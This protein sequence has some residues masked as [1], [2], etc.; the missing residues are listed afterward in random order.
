MLIKS[1]SIVFVLFKIIA[2][3]GTTPGV[4]HNCDTSA[5]CANLVP[6]ASGCI[7]IGKTG[8]G[9]CFWVSEKRGFLNNEVSFNYLFDN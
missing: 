4:Y 3:L 6:P 8:K 7:D 9:R 5:N 1:F 2:T